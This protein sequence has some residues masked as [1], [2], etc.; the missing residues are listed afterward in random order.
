MFL[1]TLTGKTITLE[2]DSEMDITILKKL[3]QNHE[4]IPPYQQRLIYAGKQLEDGRTLADY[5]IQKE[6]CIHL[7]GRLRGG[8][9]HCT[10]GRQDFDKMSS[11]SAEAIKKVL[12]IKFK[13]IKHLHQCPVT[14][15]QNYVLQGQAAL[16]NLFYQVEH[17]SLSK[18]IPDLMNI[19][20][21]STVNDDV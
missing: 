6:S 13:D 17:S 15:L 3:I 5:N 18:D 14:E 21:S 9:Y 20:L 11:H 10:S 8:M 19:V 1:K 12:E 2:V 4:G 7:C 16:S